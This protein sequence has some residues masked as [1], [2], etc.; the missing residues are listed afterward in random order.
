MEVAEG[1]VKKYLFEATARM[2]AQLG[3]LL[4]EVAS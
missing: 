2:R 4:D 1:S 3:D